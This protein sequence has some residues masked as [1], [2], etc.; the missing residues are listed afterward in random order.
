M[1]VAAAKDNT[2][3]AEFTKDTPFWM[4][5]GSLDPTSSAVTYLEQLERF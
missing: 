1:H 2:L 5:F 4:F 3:Y